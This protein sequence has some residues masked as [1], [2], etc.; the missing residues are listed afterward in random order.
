MGNGGNMRRPRS[1]MFTCL[2]SSLILISFFPGAPAVA[3]NETG[4][5][6]QGRV[7]LPNSSF[8]EVE[9]NMPKGWTANTWRAKADFALDSSVAHS[10]K[11]GVR[12]SSTGGG[13]ASW[14]A[15]RPARPCSRYRLRG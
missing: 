5:Q 10:G 15:V 9:G 13:D 7:A 4:L 2:F 11:N 1:L 6:P 3:S 12:I 8:E 14:T